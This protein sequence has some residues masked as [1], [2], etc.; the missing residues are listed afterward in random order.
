MPFAVAS[1]YL[2]DRLSLGF[3]VK[4]VAKGG[5]DRQFSINDIE[6][7]VKNKDSAATTTAADGTEEK[8]VKLDNY[9]EGGVGVGADFGLLYTPVKTM[10]PTLGISI[11]DLGGT[12]YKKFDV[13]GESLGAPRVRLPAVNTGVSVMPWE[14][15]E[16]YLRLSMDAHAINWP[17]HYSKKLNVGAEYGLGSILKLQSGLHQ[18]ALSAGF[19]FDVFLFSLRFAT[20]EEQL[21]T[22]AGQDEDLSD[23]RYIANM[24]LLI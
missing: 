6:A 24:K 18:G 17:E 23:R 10:R 21:G 22:E 7:F 13:Q 11:M 12:P 8:A 1:N 4:L 20:Y 14:E 3:G 16:T 15:G 5:I 9:V 19:E 2:E